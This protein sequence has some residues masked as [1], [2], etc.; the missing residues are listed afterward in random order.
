MSLAKIM[1]D[2]TLAADPE[3]RF[4]PNENLPVTSFLLTVPVRQA[5]NAPAESATVKVTCWRQLADAVAEQLRQGSHVL[6]EGKLMIN[7]E[8]TPEG[9]Q[10]KRFEIEAAAIEILTGAPQPLITGLQGGRSDGNT[11]TPAAQPAAPNSS[12]YASSP[13]VQSTPQP[14]TP[15]VQTPAAA[16]VG[17]TSVP[18]QGP[19]QEQPQPSQSGSFGNFQ[20]EELLT[21][22]DIPF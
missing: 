20:A 16:P 18:A 3:K 21:E 9:A 14:G 8:Q 17:V 22:D 4:T 10:T 15:P 5:G 7:G 11:Y 19:A 1:I 12:T 13:P 6:V 2:G